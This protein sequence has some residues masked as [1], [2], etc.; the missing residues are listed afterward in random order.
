MKEIVFSVLVFLLSGAAFKFYKDSKQSELRYQ[1]LIGITEEAELLKGNILKL[2]TEY[3]RSEDLL[4]E[5]NKKFKELKVEYD[6]KV[7][8]VGNLGVSIKGRE[9]S[10]SSIQIDEI[11][12]P[13]I[14]YLK[15]DKLGLYP[16]RISQDLAL[17]KEDKT[18]KQKVVVK[19]Y[20]ILDPTVKSKWAGVPYQLVETTGEVRIDPTESLG[21]AGIIYFPLNLNLGIN[22]SSQVLGT[23]TLLGLGR[24]KEDLDYKLLSV[25]A[26]YTGD[27]ITGLVT[28][29]SARLVPE[30]L[31]NSY[32]GVDYSQDKKLSISLSVGL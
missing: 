25:G 17:I 5:T 18:G 30:L 21:A 9:T 27:K 10:N 24:S 12:S 28:L 23:V 2:K 3:K 13:E 1:N 32:I 7:K 22:T 19:S 26:G 6:E 8:L 15:E 14:C 20:Y 4:A 16:F 11:D 29:V 31:T